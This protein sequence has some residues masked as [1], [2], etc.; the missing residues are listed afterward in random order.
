MC[1]QLVV[2]S[3]LAW[4]FSFFLCVCECISSFGEGVVT[5]V[6]VVLHAFSLVPEMLKHPWD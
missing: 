5:M 1:T 2:V 6:L 4:N 3:P